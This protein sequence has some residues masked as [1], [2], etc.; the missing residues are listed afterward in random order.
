MATAPVSVA[1]P[2]CRSPARTP[3]PSGPR[4]RTARRRTRD[5]FPMT[6]PARAAHSPFPTSTRTPPPTPTA[7]HR[8]PVAWLPLSASLARSSS[9]SSSAEII[10]EK[11]CLGDN[12]GVCPNPIAGRSHITL[13]RYSSRQGSNGQSP[14]AQK[15]NRA[16]RARFF[17]CS[18]ACDSI[19]VTAATYSCPDCESRC[20]LREPRRR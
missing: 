11:K 19:R 14:I 16:A 2:A 7:P 20:A 3:S 18:K 1:R 15:E 6:S 13:P 5:A 12:Q 8:T 10:T 4:P 9:A 17:D